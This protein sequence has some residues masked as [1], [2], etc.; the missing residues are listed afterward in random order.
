MNRAYSILEIKAVDDDKRII[1]GVATS[2]EPDLMDDVVEPKGAEFNL[3]I[4]FL[5]HHDSAKPI[6]HVTKAKVRPAGIDVEIH[7]KKT[8]EPGPVKDRLDSAWQDI[9]LGLVRGLSIGFK[10]LETARIEGSFGIHFLRW[11]WLELSAVTIAA[12]QAASITAIKSIDAAVLAATGHKHNGGERTVSAGAS[13]I[14]STTIVKAQ[15]AKSMKKTIAEQISAFEATRQ[16]KA[17]RMGEIMDAAGEKGETLDETAKQEYDALEAEVKSVDEHLVRL[18]AQE[19]MNKKAAVP[20]V[21]GSSDDASKSRAGTSV[22]SARSAVPDDISFARMVIAKYISAKELVSP[23]DVAKERWPNQP[24]LQVALKAAVTAGS[25][26]TMAT[27]VEPQIYAQAFIEYLWHRTI[28]GRIPGLRRVPFNIKVQRALT[29]ASVNWV[30]EGKPKP[31]GRGTLDTV[32]LGYTKIAGIVPLTDELVRF[33]NPSVEAMVRDQL[34]AA[35]VQLMDHD[36]IDPEKAAVT[37]VSP[38]SITNGVTATTATGTAYANVAADFGTAMGNFDAARIDTSNLVVV[39]GSRAARRLSLMLNS[40]GQRLFPDM[41]NT[42]GSFLGY[43]VIVSGNVDYTEDSPAEGDNI[44]F[45]KPDD[46]LVADDGGVD[47]AISREAAVQMDS[48]PDDPASASTVLISAF[49]HNLVLIRAE[50]YVNWLKARD[51]S[52]QY[53]KAAAYV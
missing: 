23:V 2:P 46:I 43:P 49:Q 38:A 45:L 48:A 53:I 8:D 30:G 41:T 35:I 36:F 22:I 4:P 19:E 29:V 14:R 40:L 37:N 21:G 7:L 24:E 1:L 34:A 6:G 44:I 15:E 47:I 32:T 10:G 20:A 51:A 18:R 17:A 39:M 31:L 42:G 13:A 9:K 28:L 25:S 26:S 27:L 11:A 52:V 5:W 12:N 3:P 16:A 50:R 33:S